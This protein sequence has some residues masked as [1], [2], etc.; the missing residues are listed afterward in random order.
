VKSEE[1]AKLYDEFLSPFSAT[2]L[3]VSSKIRKAIRYQIENNICTTST[4]NEAQR[5]VFKLI[6]L[7]VYPK[8]CSTMLESLDK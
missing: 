2:E 6:S 3:N 5:E 8:F 1:A 7:D 4:F